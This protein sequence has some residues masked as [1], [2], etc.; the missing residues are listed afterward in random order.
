[1]FTELSE[2]VS[3]GDTAGF[4]RGIVS[5]TSRILFLLVPFALYLVVFAPMLILLLNSGSFTQADIEL[6][7]SYLRMLS[8]SLPF[9]GVCTYLQKVCSSYRRMNF[10]AVATIVASVVQVVFCV[11]LTPVIGLDA[12]AFSS[13]FFFIA[14]DA[15]T[16]AS[17][18]RSLGALGVRSMFATFF[19][20][21]FFGACGAVAGWAIMWGIQNILRIAVEGPAMAAAVCVAAGIPAVVL[22]YGLAIL[23]RAPEA[24]F[25]TSLV[26]RARRG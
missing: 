24:G 4:K 20:S 15:V 6:T 26:S 18:R 7:T 10:Y 8:L 22:S 16:F 1:M 3:A 14:V 25:L 2:S 9:Y 5:G 11:V 21:L 13:L 12:V 17:L 19:R 23:C